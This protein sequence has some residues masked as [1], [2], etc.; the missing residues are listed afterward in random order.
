MA[1]IEGGITL[2]AIAALVPGIDERCGCKEV[3][4]MLEKM[5]NREL[6]TGVGTGAL[7]GET[8][9]IVQAEIRAGIK[10]RV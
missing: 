8:V 1:S 4:A 2:N 6:G 3:K 5:L 10:C 9:V 7:V